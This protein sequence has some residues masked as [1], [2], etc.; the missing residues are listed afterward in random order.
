MFGLPLE[1][2]R[3]HTNANVDHVELADG[4]IFSV[5]RAN[6]AAAKALLAASKA[7]ER[8][9]QNNWRSRR[10]ASVF[11]EDLFPRFPEE[12]AMAGSNA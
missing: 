8:R 3:D 7:A 1:T 2:Q 6:L 10:Y 4:T 9:N 5:P 11:D 12:P